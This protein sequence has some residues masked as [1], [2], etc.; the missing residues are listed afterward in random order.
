MRERKGKVIR[1]VSGTT[2]N[3]YTDCTLVFW[4]SKYTWTVAVLLFIL[5]ILGMQGAVRYL[6]SDHR[7]KLHLIEGLI[8]RPQ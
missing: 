6:W 1:Q 5:L 4:N 2:R 3:V 8:Y 7:Y